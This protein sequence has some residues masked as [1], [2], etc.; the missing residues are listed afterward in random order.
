MKVFITGATGFIGQGVIPELLKNG[1][2]VAGLARDSTKASLLESQGVEAHIGDLS[3]ISVLKDAARNSDAIL[4]LGY[5]HDFANMA[6]STSIDRAA[7]EAFAEGFAGEN[8]ILVIAGGVLYLPR[9]VVGTEET[10]PMTDVLHGRAKSE[11][12]LA[13]LAKEK[14]F[15]GVVARFSPSVH[16]KSCYPIDWSSDKSCH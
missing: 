7:I 6:N 16:G 12:L 5:V 13:E 1:H 3:D 2:S 10:L 8:K 9:G 11:Y 14:G 4:H 15:R